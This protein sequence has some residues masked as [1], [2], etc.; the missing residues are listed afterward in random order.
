M[1]LGRRELALR[2]R[3]EREAGLDARAQSVVLGPRA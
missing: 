1:M 3:G 2:E